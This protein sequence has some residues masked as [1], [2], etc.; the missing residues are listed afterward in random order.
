MNDPAV[1]IGAHESP[2]GFEH[3]QSRRRHL[4]GRQAWIDSTHFQR[5]VKPIDM[6]VQAKG[7]MPKRSSG[8]GD[9]VAEQN[10]AVENRNGG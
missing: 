8:L 10:S 5:L 3:L 2:V 7:G 6:I 4:L 9:T 1:I